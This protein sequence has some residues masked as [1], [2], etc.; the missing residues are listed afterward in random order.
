[1]RPT[2]LPPEP[3]AAAYLFGGARRRRP[4][5][6]GPH[7][8]RLP[9]HGGAAARHGVDHHAGGDVVVHGQLILRRGRAPFPDRSC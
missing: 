9:A 7:R 1:M 5:I 6:S 4:G 3:A 8:R 2:G